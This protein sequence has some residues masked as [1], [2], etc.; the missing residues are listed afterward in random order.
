[1]A[2]GS[3]G[4]QT[5]V[6][7][8]DPWSGVQPYLSDLFSGAQQQFNQGAEYFPG[9]TVVPFS[10]D[11]LAGMDTIRA[12]AGSD[13]GA[14]DAQALVKR[15]M[16]GGG[17]TGAGGAGGNPLW[18]RISQFAG[19]MTSAGQG[20]LTAAALGGMAVDPSAVAAAGA[21]PNGYL[22]S[23]G[24]A[25]TATTGGIGAVRDAAG[26]EITAG[27]EA[28]NRIASGSEITGN[29]MLDRTFN[30]A[31]GQVRDNTNAAFSLAGRY[32]SGAH[33]AT[34]GDTLNNLATSVY[35]GAY[36]NERGRQMQ[37][38]GELGNRQASDIATRMA[39]ATTAA[40]LE[41]NDLAR[42]LSAQGL[43]GQL[44]ES[45][46]GRQMQGASTAAGIQA[47]NAQRQI[48]AAG[49]QAGIE[50]NDL[51]RN[52]GLLGQLASYDL[53]QTGQGLQAAG[54]LG[55][56]RDLSNAGG[57]D[58]LN[59]GNMQEQMAG[60]ELDDL[61]QRWNFSQQAPWDALGKYGGILGGMGNLG[62]TTTTTGPKAKS[63]GLMGGLSGAA[64][65]AGIASALLPAAT[66]AGPVGWGIAGLG[67]LLGL[68]G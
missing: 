35:G 45:G 20:A 23:I 5:S 33:A 54:M 52:A 31:A 42:N 18:D 68:F 49:A 2:S 14:G 61:M 60:Q 10:P 19:K 39:G 46:Y 8:S 38:I 41:Q 53:S 48:G 62:G 50:Q 24:G 32:G 56:L 13:A 55:G 6:Q 59:L 51:S 15:I 67:G 37:A 47:D 28:L 65:G 40:G 36:E 22:S 63:G 12:N 58:L 11:T 44:A 57:R 66:A 3:S 9:S 43:L 29:P 21:A 4:T 34:M 25:G 17:A 16:A 30:K 64:G 27:N 7:K 26:R 1:M